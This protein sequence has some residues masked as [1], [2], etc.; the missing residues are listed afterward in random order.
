MCT[1]TILQFGDAVS[2]Y[3]HARS[4]SVSTSYFGGIRIACNRDELR[5]RS[6]ALPPQ[7]RRCGDRHAL[8]PIDPE[9]DGTWIAVNDCLVMA[10]LLNLNPTRTEQIDTKRAPKSRGGIVPRMM[11]C[12]TARSATAAL[13]DIDPS[14]YAPFRVVVVDHVSIHEIC[15]DG[16][17]VEVC[18]IGETNRPLMFTSSGLGDTLVELPRRALFDDW[19][20]NSEL[21]TT[22]QQDAFHRHHWS[23]KP[24]L[25]VCM[26]RDRART[27]SFTVVDIDE[28]HATMTYHP[29]APDRPATPVRQSLA[30]RQPT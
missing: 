3:R 13:D 4:T 16:K 12:E 19:F 5:T 10:T 8:M 23:D 20:G 27:V 26:S 28:N 25:S 7:L 24:E 11:R 14:D 9:S 18:E 22:D 1:V 21:S 30:V 29:D 2:D 6:A 17:R 15:S